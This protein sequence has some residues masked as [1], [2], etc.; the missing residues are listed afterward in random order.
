ML[1]LPLLVLLLQPLLL[2]KLL[3]HDI[4]VLY[5][6]AS[7]T[8][9]AEAVGE[10]TGPTPVYLELNQNKAK[11]ITLTATHID[12]DRRE[13]HGEQNTLGGAKLIYEPLFAN[14]H[15]LEMLFDSNAPA[16]QYKSMTSDFWSSRS[17]AH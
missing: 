7:N 4:P 15:P 17:S 2:Q 6:V 16:A 10:R 8:M 11:Q 9:R 1:L 13:W 5:K 12:E 3:L 14:T